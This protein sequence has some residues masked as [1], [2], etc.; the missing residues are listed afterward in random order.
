MEAKSSAPAPRAGRTLQRPSRCRRSLF[1]IDND[2]LLPDRLRRDFHVSKVAAQL[3][4]RSASSVLPLA[5]MAIVLALGTSR[6]SSSSRFAPNVASK[7]AHASDIA[8]W[9]V[10]AGD[11]TGL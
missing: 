5:S 8:A 10:E 9:S 3:G 11:K 2:E 6:R 7:E 4:V 1:D